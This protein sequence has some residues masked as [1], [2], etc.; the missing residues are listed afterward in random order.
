MLAGRVAENRH[1]LANDHPLIERERKAAADITELLGAVRKVRDALYER[2]FSMLFET[3]AP[4]G[5]PIALSTDEEPIAAQDV[6]C[7]QCTHP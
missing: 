2:T 4:P 5:T 7:A 6:R 3:W 1:A